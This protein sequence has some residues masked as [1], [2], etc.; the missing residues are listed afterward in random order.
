MNKMAGSD[1]QESMINQARAES[2]SDSERSENEENG[3]V[4][5]NDELIGI[6]VKSKEQLMACTYP[7]KDPNDQY[8]KPKY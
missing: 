2:E 1:F 3:T 6:S 8:V 5:N 7:N 4:S